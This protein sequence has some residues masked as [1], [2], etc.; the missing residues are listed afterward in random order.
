MED[1]N[2]RHAHERDPYLSFDA[3]SHTYMLGDRVMKSV[4]TIIERCFPQFDAIKWAN[5][6]A[7]KEGV[8]P[9]VILDRWER[10]AQ[11]ARDL[12]TAMH[13]RIERYYLDKSVGRE[14]EAP[15][16]D[17]DAYG[18]FYNF[19]RSTT[20][21]PYR[22]EWRIY[23][24]EYGVAGTLDFLERRPDGS[25]YIYD[26]KR[27]K[28]LIAAGSNTVVLES[29]YKTTGLHPVSNLPDTSY[30]HYALQLSIYRLILEEKYG[31]EVAGMCLGVFHPSY[32]RAYIIRN[33][34]Y[35]HREALAVL[36][37]A[38]QSR[39]QLK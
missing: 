33:I 14:P 9:Q 5:Y 19:A 32:E 28:K 36:L 27:S 6:K 4:T 24:E 35:L 1:C 12:G 31:I 23:H 2:T 8:S 16:K 34:P 29:K 21:H 37:S 13:E 30:W 18:L 17:S 11:H 38:A 39:V 22:T 7:L 25:Y 20:L 26:W 15:S 3:P 10:E